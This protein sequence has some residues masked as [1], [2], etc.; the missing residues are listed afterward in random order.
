MDEYL[1]TAQVAERVGIHPSTIS[2]W[3]KEGR[4]APL[5]RLPGHTGAMLWAPGV[6]DQLLAE[7]APAG[8]A[9][10]RPAGAA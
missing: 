8:S 3:V 1:T 9:E 10:D 7:L 4:I 5:G 2:R 6:V